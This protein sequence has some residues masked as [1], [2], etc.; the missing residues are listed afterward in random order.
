MSA[1]AGIF[2]DEFSYSIKFLEKYSRLSGKCILLS[3]N[4]RNDNKM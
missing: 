4:K 1:L 3:D 2:F